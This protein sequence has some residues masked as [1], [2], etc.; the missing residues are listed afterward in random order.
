VDIGPSEPGYWAM[1]VA[2]GTRTCPIGRA[3]RFVAL[4]RQERDLV[5]YFMDLEER[6]RGG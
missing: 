6:A 4:G 1:T 3:Y 2:P 5:S